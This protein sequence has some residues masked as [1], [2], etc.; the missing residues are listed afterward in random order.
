MALLRN[1]IHK[2]ILYVITYA[3]LTINEPSVEPALRLGHERVTTFHINNGCRHAQ[4]CPPNL[5][6]SKKP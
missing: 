2:E 1:Y 4:F 3:F 6:F 5:F